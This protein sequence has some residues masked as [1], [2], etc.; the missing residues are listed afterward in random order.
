M[1]IEC[2]SQTIRYAVAVL[3][4]TALGMTAIIVDG[5][6]GNTIALAVAGGIGYMV[7]DWRSTREVKSNGSEEEE[8]SE[9]EVPAHES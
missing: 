6:I 9:E 3:A 1:K 4:L 2:N 5:D 7:K 8:I